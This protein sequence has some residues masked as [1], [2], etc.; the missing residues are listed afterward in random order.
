M[1][2]L[3]AA[4]L[5]LPAHAGL[6][7]N[8]FNADPSGVLTILDPAKWV[9]SGG[10]GGTGYISLTDAVN[11]LTDVR[12]LRRPPHQWVASI[13]ARPV[14]GLTLTADAGGTADLPYRGGMVQTSTTF[15]QT[16]GYFAVRA[17]IPSAPG[18]KPSA[19]LQGTG[20][21]DWLPLIDIIQ[22]P[23]AWSRGGRHLFCGLRYRDAAGAAQEVSTDW[24]S[25]TSLAEGWH[26]Y[27]VWWRPGRI[28]WHV[29]GQQIAST[30]VGVPSVPCHLSLSCTVAR[31]DGRWLGDP[32]QASWP[33][34]LRIAWV[35]VW[36]ER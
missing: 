4:C 9:S 12:L 8:N 24:G 30:E 14:S 15:A 27:A 21:Q 25:P 16:Y 32:A 31:D 29:D 36:R 17:W 20:G 34:V 18:V 10:V 11:G 13:E 22:A 33:Q 26:T 35:R 1:A 6:F 2:S 23:G 5:A 19:C 28:T 3:A 7:N